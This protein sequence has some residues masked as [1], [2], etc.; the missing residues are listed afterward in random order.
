MRRYAKLGPTREGSKKRRGQD[1]G[2]R[3]KKTGMGGWGEGQLRPKEKKLLT[4]KYK[5]VP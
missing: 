1:E 2:E 3:Y 4:I 5:G